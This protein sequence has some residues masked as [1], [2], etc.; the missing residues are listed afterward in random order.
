MQLK[1]TWLHK[2]GQRD[3]VGSKADLVK[4]KVLLVGPECHTIVFHLDLA[5][6]RNHKGIW[7]S[8]L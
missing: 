6:S 7:V 3:I 1:N 5:L 2:K 8:A 4:K